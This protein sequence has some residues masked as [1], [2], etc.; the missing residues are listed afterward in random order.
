MRDYD[1]ILSRLQELD[2]PDSR[3]DRLA[4]V[5]GYPIVRLRLE[6]PPGAATVLLTGGTHGDEP[7]G[8]ETCLSLLEGGLEPFRSRFSFEVLPCLNAHG[9]VRDQ[10]HNAQDVDVNWWGDR[11]GVPEVEVVQDLVAGRRFELVMDFHEDWESAGYYI[12]ELRRDGPVVGQQVVEAVGAVCPVNGS[13]MI[14]GLPARNG[15]IAPDAEEEAG[16]RGAGIP[17]VMF[18]EHTDHLLT[19]ES[20]TGRAMAC[21]VAA[22]RA[23][24]TAVLQAHAPGH[25]L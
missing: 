25:E 1:T 10:R 4:Q 2:L 22:H 19:S 9:W 13:P 21:R 7:A 17:L 12:Y 3:M 15:H 18:F 6:G 8:V 14:E 5:E 20:P 23:A 11:P 16:R 24:L